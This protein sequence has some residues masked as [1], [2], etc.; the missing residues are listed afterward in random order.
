MERRFVF[1]Y[2]N[3]VTSCF[4]PG[5]M[6]GEKSRGPNG[7]RI[8]YPT[9]HK[10]E[11]FKSRI[12]PTASI[13]LEGTQFV[14][15]GGEY[16]MTGIDWQS[17]FDEIHREPG[18]SDDEIA[19]LLATVFAPVS[20]VEAAQI[21]A[22]QS[23]PFPEC[24]PQYD[25]WIPIDP[26]NWTFPEFK[27]PQSFL[28]LLHWSDGLNARTGDR[29]F[30]FFDSL[31]TNTGIRAMMLAYH[32]PEYMPLAVP[33]AFNGGGTFYLFDMRLAPINGEYPIVCC[34]AGALGFECEFTVTIAQSLFEACIGCECVDDLRFPDSPC[35]YI[36]L[37]LIRPLPLKQLAVLNKLFKIS[38]SIAQL[39]TR[40]AIVPVTVTRTRLDIAQALLSDYPDLI[41][42]LLARDQDNPH[43]SH[44]LKIA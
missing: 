26:Q 29:E 8:R 16:L 33:F 9:H 44:C 42:V 11:K 6:T 3:L 14:S 17:V 25:S 18:A 1:F 41:E 30:G 2:K 37:V 39:K 19:R 23:N 28:D 10:A 31:G 21:Q 22:A 34:G 7:T 15:L 13:Q 24:D 38:D 5:K 35:V 43:V 40:L 27:L 32:I 20:A 12:S 4:T 36:D